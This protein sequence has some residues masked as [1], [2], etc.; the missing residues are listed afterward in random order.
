MDSIEEQEASQDKP[1][2][3]KIWILLLILTLL[4]FAAIGV[5]LFAIVKN[6]VKIVTFKGEQQIMTDV[7]PE[8][9]ANMYGDTMI[10]FKE[11]GQGTSYAYNE[12][13]IEVQWTD[14]QK[15]LFGK[16]IVDL[17]KIQVNFNYSEDLQDIVQGL[18][19]DRIDWKSATFTE[20]DSAFILTK[21]Q[22]GNKVD[23]KAIEEHIS[24]NLTTKDLVISLD[25]FQYA[26]PED[27]VTAEKYNDEFSKWSSFCV[28]Y[29]NGFIITTEDIKPFFELTDEY[30]IVFKEGMKKDLTEKVQEWV[31][32]DLQSYNT[33]GGT[34][35]FKTHDG[36][37]VEL[38]GVN[39]GDVM[40]K[41]KEVEFLIES[42]E[43]LQSCSQRIPEMS[44]DDPD[45]IQSNVIEVSIEDQHLWYWQNGEV[46]ME[47]DVVTG[48]K[49]KWDTPK[50]VYRILDKINGTYLVGDDY[51]VWVDKWIR[52]W[53]G[54]G[55]HDAMWRYKF[56][57][58]VYTRNGSH[59]CINLP[60][61][62]AVEIYDM[63]DMG[64]CVV[65]Y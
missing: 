18:N 53:K 41:Q 1:K 29:T 2:K 61:D 52:F 24:S 64:D 14:E 57:A 59:G 17:D 22:E 16:F 9:F 8:E 10:V 63:V 23:I 11:D 40:D 13:G 60:H 31:D 44:I 47:T 19:K 62:F 48:W 4:M 30:K 33:L 54:Y 36:E 38:K 37:E 35:K 7:T 51:N 49:N 15:I 20:T 25:D 58:D 27:F 56:G 5:L 43:K 34:F 32:N 45:D 26:Q 28:T 55:L 46:V 65:I 50:G 6:D 12:L 39:Y 42:I 3:K 21:E